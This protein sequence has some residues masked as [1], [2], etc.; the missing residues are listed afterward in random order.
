MWEGVVEHQ[1]IGG[2]DQERV[3]NVGMVAEELP[4]A[5]PPLLVSGHRGLDADRGDIGRW[6]GN[7]MQQNE[8]RARIGKG[9]NGFGVVG[10][11]DV[12][13]QVLVAGEV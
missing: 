12:A 1:H 4:L 10:E 9:D 11:C 3:P 8:R 13:L 2:I 5:E 7:V 6:A